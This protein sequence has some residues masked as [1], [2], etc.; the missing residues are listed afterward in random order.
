[1]IWRLA[2]LN[3]FKPPPPPG[4]KGCRQFKGDG[5]VVVDVL[6]YVPPMFVGVL[7]WSM[8]WFAKL[9]VLYS[10]AFVLTRKRELVALLLLSFGYLVTVY[11]LML[12]L[13]MP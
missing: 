8:F 6:F 2:Q 5:S 1:M 13:T 10:F 12:I 7:C 9:C 11:V 3:A 4:G